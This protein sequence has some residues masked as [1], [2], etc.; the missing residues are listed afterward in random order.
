MIEHAYIDRRVMCERE[1]RNT[2]ANAR[3]QNSYALE[4]FRFS[5]PSHCRAG[6]EHGLSHRLNRATDVW[7]DQMIGAFQFRWSADFVIWQ[8]QPQGG[9]AH[10]VKNA[11]GF[12][13]TVRLG[14]PLRQNY[15]SRA[16]LALSLPARRKQ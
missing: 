15:Y 12:H 9:H 14:I 2:R 4:P 5:E 11:T 7:A 1:K 10:A 3:T 16:R 8:G 13:V 6:I